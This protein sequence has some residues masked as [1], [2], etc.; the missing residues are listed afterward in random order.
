MIILIFI[1]LN[2]VFPWDLRI[3]FNSYVK[4]FDCCRCIQFV[5]PWHLHLLLFAFQNCNQWNMNEK[6][7]MLWFEW[8]WILIMILQWLQLSSL[9]SVLFPVWSYWGDRQH[10]EPRLCE[11][12]CVGFLL[13]RETKSTLW[14]VSRNVFIWI[15]KCT[16]PFF[17]NDNDG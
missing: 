16:R 8:W 6:E 1:C 15:C 11:E 4:C 7:W 13:W 14:R 2:F 9:L 5:L 3:L 12:V 17:Y 10:V